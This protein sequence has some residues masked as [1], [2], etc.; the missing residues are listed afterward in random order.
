MGPL[1]RTML[2]GRLT[3]LRTQR[4]RLKVQIDAIVKSLL[5]HFEPLDHAMDYI[6]NIDP[7]VIMINVQDISEK[8]AQLVKVETEIERLKAEAGDTTS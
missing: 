8:H 1:N 2:I 6:D 7:T 3:E 4:H 5:I